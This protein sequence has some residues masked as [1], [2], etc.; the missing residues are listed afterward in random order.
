MSAR[1][2]NTVLAAVAAEAARAHARYGDFTSAH[3]SYGVLAEEMAELLEAIR[4]NDARGVRDEARQVAAVAY[5]LTILSD[6][7]L[8]GERPAFS[9]RSGW[10]R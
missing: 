1:K 6:L 7:A 8:R 10:S 3:E 9:E 5:R 4:R 2:L